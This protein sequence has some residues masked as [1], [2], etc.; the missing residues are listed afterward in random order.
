MVRFGVKG[1]PDIVCVIRGR[2]VGL[3][4]KRLGEFLDKDQI[5][6]RENL[7]RA[8]GAYCVARSVEDVDEFLRQLKAEG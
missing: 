7:T 6:F 5:I 2:F 4:I 3:E 8:G 1:A